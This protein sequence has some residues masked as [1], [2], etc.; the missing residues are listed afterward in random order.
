MIRTYEIDLDDKL[1]EDSSKI[2]ESLGSDIDS[3][4]KIFLTQSVLR[5][6]FPFEIAVP[7]EKNEEIKKENMIESEAVQS[8]SEKSGSVEN[9][10]NGSKTDNLA[11]PEISSAGEIKNQN[12]DAEIPDSVKIAALEKDLSELEN[13]EKAEK[14]DSE[15]QETQE[16]Q[17]QNSS[18]EE[19]VSGEENQNPDAENSEDEDETA[20]ENLFAQWTVE[21]AGNDDSSGQKISGESE[22]RS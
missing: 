18:D 16:T 17:P 19:N 22:V 4:I 14:F 6:G 15:N 3:A 10:D 11:N 12:P 7:D 20:P 13:P 21:T 8:I 9:N 5:K 2:F 1:V